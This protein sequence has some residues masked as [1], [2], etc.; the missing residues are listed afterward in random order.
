MSMVP[1]APHRSPTLHLRLRRAIGGAGCL[2]AALVLPAA[3][4]ARAATAGPTIYV[5]DGAW[6]HA[7]T[8]IDPET[9]SVRTI[10]L[11]LQWQAVGFASSPSGATEYLL[12]E[13]NFPWSPAR[14]IPTRAGSATAGAPT[15]VGYSPQYV[16]VN[17]DGRT[18]YVLD[19]YD[20]E[21]SVDVPGAIVPVDL[22]TGAPG[23]AIKVGLNPQGITVAPDGQRAWVPD[24]TVDTGQPTG[25]TPVD[26]LTG[27]AGPAIH[28][29]AIALA[30]TPDS[31]WLYAATKSRLV[32][33]DASTGQS[34]T[35]GLGGTAPAA[36]LVSSDGKTLYV[37][38]MLDTRNEP[39]PASGI[40]TLTPVSTESDTVGKP[41]VLA[42]LRGTNYD[43]LVDTGLVE[44]PHGTSLYVLGASVLVQ[45]DAASAKV[46]RVIKVSAS[47]TEPATD[48][49]VDPD[50]ATVYVLLAG[51]SGGAPGSRATRG[52]V[53]PVS[54]VTGAIG[55]PI[56]TGYGGNLMSIAR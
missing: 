27:T 5:G 36:L 22:A 51:E 48:L 12:T 23:K 56:A 55:K 49:A 52:S 11:G 20:R 28:V 3:P 39:G 7:V 2:A 14:L 31:A 41:I 34:T 54:V 18:A 50:G 25:V 38:G 21:G 1:T 19:A 29:P 10:A 40:A 17:P 45:V 46:V 30:V 33:I 44:T 47:A 26:L 53:V 24:A 15:A 16:T 8:V 9:R 13:G 6:P 37:L 32:R 4:A 42:G 35:V 43:D